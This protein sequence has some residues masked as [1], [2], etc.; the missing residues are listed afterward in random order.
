[1]SS[2]CSG[3]VALQGIRVESLPLPP[4]LCMT[5]GKSH[6]LHLYIQSLVRLQVPVTRKEHR[7]EDSL[8]RAEAQLSSVPCL[9]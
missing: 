2:E 7:A 9:F 5:T 8:P 3:L 4:S 1:M 6:H